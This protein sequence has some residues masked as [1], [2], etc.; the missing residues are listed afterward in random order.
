MSGS[1]AVTSSRPD[2]ARASGPTPPRRFGLVNWLGF[3]TLYRRE[4][5]RYFAEW[6]EALGGAAVS[7]LLFLAVFHLA[8]E[9]APQPLPGV[10]LVAFLIPGLI[11]V[12][13]AQKSFEAAAFSILYDK[14]EGIIVD[15]LTPPLSAWERALGYA[16][17]AASSGLASA[18]TV[19]LVLLPF[20]PWPQIQPLPFMFFLVAAAL[21]HALFGIVAGLWADR[22]DNL[23]ATQTF[24][25][26]PLV[27]L[28][29]AFFPI[30]DLPEAGRLAVMLNPVHYAVDGLRFA[31]LGQSE[32]A[33]AFGAVLLV[34]LD[35]ALFALVWRLFAAGYKLRA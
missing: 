20:A 31:W 1:G 4:V 35:L 16:L 24:G 15:V 26:I 10:S 25:L 29:G 6:L 2:L 3:A 23:A 11:T 34:L 5:K 32:L 14:L 19:A 22:W 33:P 8:L 9:S 27:Y 28:S 30:S 18:A 7:S 21:F 12:S 17:A 13:I